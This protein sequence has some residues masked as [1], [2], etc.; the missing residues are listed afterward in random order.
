MKILSKLDQWADKKFDAWENKKELKKWN[1]LILKSCK[2]YWIKEE[3]LR[4]MYMG[5]QKDVLEE[6]NNKGSKEVHSLQDFRNSPFNIII[7]QRIYDLNREFV[8]LINGEFHNSLYALTRQICELYIRLIYCR[9]DNSSIKKLTDEKKQS[10]VIADVIKNLRGK[11]SFPYLKD[12]ENNKFLDSTL[13][14]FYYFSNLYHVSGVSLSQNMWVTKEDEPSTRLYIDKPKLEEGDR[15]LIFSKK[16]VVTNEQYKIL[17]HQFCTFS[18]LSI[19]ELKLLEE[20]NPII[21][22]ETNTK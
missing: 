12:T 11:V 17:I 2:K 9:Y 19:T 8:F 1:K 5:I 22:N 18:G 10:L 6:V 4:K 13:T 7:K 3:L 15:L 16:S 14:W 20:Q 21:K